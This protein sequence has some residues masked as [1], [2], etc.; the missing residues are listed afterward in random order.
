MDLPKYSFAAQSRLPEVQRTSSRD[1]IVVDGILSLRLAPL[2]PVYDGSVHVD[3]PADQRYRRRIARDVRERGR[4]QADVERQ[5][6]ATVVPMHEKHVA[7]SREHAAHVIDCRDG[8]R[9]EA[10]HE[11]LAIARALLPR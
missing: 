7:P 6:T 4:P 5:W 10:V 1:L 3:A 2:R 8:R 11:F 9:D